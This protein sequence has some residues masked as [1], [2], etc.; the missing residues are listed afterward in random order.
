[1]KFDQHAQGLDEDIRRPSVANLDDTVLRVGS[2]ERAHFALVLA[3]VPDPS[4]SC[5]SWLRCLKMSKTQGKA[6]QLGMQ[7]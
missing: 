7:S 4:L 6:L 1:M 5:W 3:V 2:D